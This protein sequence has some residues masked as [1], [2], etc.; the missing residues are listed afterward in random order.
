MRLTSDNVDYTSGETSLLEE[1]S[2]AEG[3]ERGKLAGLD[4]DSVACCKG[5]GEF[6]GKHQEGEVPWDNLANNANGLMT[7]IGKAALVNFS[8]LSVDLVGPTPIVAEAGSS[9]TGIK[10]LGD[11]KSLSVIECFDSR[12]FIDIT[13]D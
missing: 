6:P 4:D 3:R 8:N 1:S 13:L 9:L 5:G 11:G 7:S 10:A 12:D 2:N